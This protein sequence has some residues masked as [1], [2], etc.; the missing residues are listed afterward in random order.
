MRIPQLSLVQVVLVSLACLSGASNFREDLNAI[1]A[2]AVFAGDS[3][4]TNVSEACK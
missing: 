4:Y 1:G 3:T 2:H